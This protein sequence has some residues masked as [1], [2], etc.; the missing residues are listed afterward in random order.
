MYSNSYA[1]IKLGGH[2]SNKFEIKKGTEQGHPLSP[3]LFKIFLSDLSPLLEFSNCPALSNISISH[4]LWADDLIML[5]LDNKT[6]QLQ[7][8]NLTKFCRTWGIEINELK[9]KVVVFGKQY[10]DKNDAIKFLL[11]SEPLKIVDSYCYLGIILHQSGDVKPT[12]LDL[13]IKAMRAFFGLK[14][15]VMRSKLSFKALITLFDSLIKP[16][17][18]YGAP[19]WA[20]ISAISKT[21]VKSLHSNEEVSHNLLRKISGSLQEKVHLSFLRWAL[22][23]HRKSSIVDIWEKQADF[24]CSI[25]HSASV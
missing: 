20:P 3:D 6:S 5:S 16:I 14:R 25:N 4:L 18:L 10:V 7:L 21:V 2:I 12:Q 9:T 1:Y 22:G 19:I 23:V 11:D 24:H 15:V 17:I 8:D 13:K